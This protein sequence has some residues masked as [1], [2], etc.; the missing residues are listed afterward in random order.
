MMGNYWV[1]PELNA[2]FNIFND[3]VSVQFTHRWIA[4]LTGII[5]LSFAYR[6]KSFPLAGIVFLQIGL[7]ILTLL[8]QVPIHLAATHQ[9]GA[10]ILTGFII[11][12]LQRTMQ[13]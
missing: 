9:G 4:I 1:P 3:P 7:G 10:F 12:H 11:Y 13:K 5:V 6:V 8:M 2:F